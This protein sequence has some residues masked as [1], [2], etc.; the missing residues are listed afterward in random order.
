M[1]PPS[2]SIPKPTSNPSVLQWTGV[3]Q[4]TQDEE[5]GLLRLDHRFTDKLSGY[6]RFTKNATDIFAPNSAPPYG[7]RNLDAPTSG[8]FDFLYLVSPTSHQRTPDR[9]RLR[10][11]A[12]LDS[13]RGGSHHQHPEPFFHSWRQPAHRHRHYAIAGGS[14]VQFARRPHAQGGR[15]DPARATDRARF[16]PFRW[17]GQLRQSLRFPE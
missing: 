16:Q 13:F 11:A 6:F 17:H 3:G 4:S 10:A 9:G 14:M 12:E 7:T 1:K 5:V 2:T 15:G 8:L